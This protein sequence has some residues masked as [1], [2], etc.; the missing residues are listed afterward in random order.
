VPCRAVRAQVLGVDINGNRP[1]HAVLRCL[2]YVL[3][4]AAP[5]VPPSLGPAV[6]EAEAAETAPLLPRLI[7]VKSVQLHAALHNER[8]QLAS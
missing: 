1:L 6:S 5:P 4:P 3:N 2:H 7:I 8:R